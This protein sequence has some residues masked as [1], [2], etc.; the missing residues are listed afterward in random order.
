MNSLHLSPHWAD[1]TD[2]FLIKILRFYLIH[3][4]LENVEDSDKISF[5]HLFPQ[6]GIC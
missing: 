2:L 3:K 1:Q 5:L 6:P 4:N